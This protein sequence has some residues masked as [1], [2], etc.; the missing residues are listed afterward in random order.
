[1]MSCTLDIL[2]LGGA[3]E[4]EKDLVW[5]PSQQPGSRG[6]NTRTTPHKLLIPASSSIIILFRVNCYFD[7]KLFLKAVS[8]GIQ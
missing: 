7:L 5:S 6:V 1:M 3:F 2:V 8:E 4:V